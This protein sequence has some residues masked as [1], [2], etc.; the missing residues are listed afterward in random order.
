MSFL[1]W[2]VV[3][4]FV[5]FCRVCTLVSY[6]GSDITTVS[7][8]GKWC[9]FFAVCVRL[10]FRHCMFTFYKFIAVN[11]IYWQL[12]ITPHLHMNKLKKGNFHIIILK[13]STPDYVVLGCR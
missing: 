11:H 13:Q 10:N 7:V 12:K 8:L 4:H 9:V 2:G 5:F 6:V 1:H 3:K